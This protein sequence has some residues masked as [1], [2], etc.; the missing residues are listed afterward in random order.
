[1]AD[2]SIR[3][4]FFNGN[5][6]DVWVNGVKVLTAHK[7]S[8]KKKN[9]YEEV[10]APNGQGVVRV[11]TGHTVEV[12]FA[13]RP[14]GDEDLKDIFDDMTDVSI[15]VA[16]TNISGKITRRVK[17]DNITFDE[18]TLAEFEKKKV[19]EIEFSGQAETYQILQEK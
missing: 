14:T 17:A 8:I 11:L 6:G 7:A 12:S 18:E 3:N 2:T 10:P 15:I 13:Y 4:D 5:K 1:M 16:E 19:K 9:S